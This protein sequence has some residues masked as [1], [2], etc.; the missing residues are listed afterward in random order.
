MCS[1]LAC[2]PDTFRCLD[3]TCV[4][5]KLVCNGIND[6]SDGSD[7]R[8]MMCKRFHACRPGEFKCANGRCVDETDIC[9]GENDCTDNSDEDDCEDPIC[10]WNTCSQLCFKDVNST[11]VCKCTRGFH[12]TPDGSCLA[13][14]QTATLILVV[15]AELRLMS[16]YKAGAANQLFGKHVLTNA[17]GYKVD[18]IDV[19]HKQQ[20]LTVFWTNNHNKMVESMHIQF[21]ER[22]RTERDTAIRTVLSDL[23]QPR[24]LAVDWV[25]QKLYVTDLSRIV[26][27]TL[28]GSQSYTLIS[29]NMKDPRD[30]VLAPSEGLLFWADWGPKA[31]IETAYM[32]GNKRRVLVDNI[33]WPTGLAIDYPKQRL[34]WADPKSRVIASV[35]FNGT[36]RHITHHFDEGKLL[37]SC[38]LCMSRVTPLVEFVIVSKLGKE[39]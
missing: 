6:C 25:S 18:T 16:P 4:S 1:Q 39:R 9:D 37:T 29:G 27:S 2:P 7:E 19:Y 17:Q 23:K 26:V 35:N 22:Y 36:A 12:K 11:H 28:N 32:D 14:G 5:A 31:V 21:N 10:R 30:I 34:Y 8:S 33:I 13:Y 38:L 24:G 3:N 20:R 15:E